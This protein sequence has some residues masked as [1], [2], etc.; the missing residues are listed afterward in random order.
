M[1]AGSGAV[2]EV[3]GVGACGLSSLGELERALVAAAEVVV[4]GERHLGML[5]PASGQDLVAWPVPLMSALPSLVESWGDRL[6][7]V[8]ASGDPLVSGIATTLIELA[9]ASRV[10]VHPAVS[11]ASLAR[12][13]MGWSAEKSEVVTL[14]GRDVDRLRRYLSPRARLVV[15]MTGDSGP[16]EVAALLVDE[17][18]DASRITVLGDLGSRE[19]SRADGLARSWDGRLTPRLY[20]VAV[21]CRLDGGEQIVR[22]LVP[23]LADD[24]FEHDGQ[25]TRRLV[26]AAALAHLAPQPGDVMWDL[27]A[28]AGSVGIEFARQHPSNR[29]YAVERDPI[30]ADRVRRNARGLGVPGLCVRQ[31]SSADL[32]AELPTPDAVFIGGGAAPSVVELAWRALSPG[33][34]LVVHGVTVETEQVLLASRL[35]YGGSLSRIGV[36]ELEPIGSFTGW[37]PARAVVQWSVSKPATQLDSAV[38]EDDG[39]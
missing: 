34:R 15:L 38:R 9:G 36:E 26:R 18:Y 8:L 33:G 21:E 31:G 1:V 16:A 20:V 29:V 6:V 11:S 17:G 27:G 3:V 32:L 5:E 7:V 13:R 10:R 19:E 28:G 24:A 37:K 12:A 30:R 25:L 22:S 4:G 2:I 35:T 23:G 14:V 39:R